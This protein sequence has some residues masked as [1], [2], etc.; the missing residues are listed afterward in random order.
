[1]GLVASSEGLGFEFEKKALERL[2]VVGS[3]NAGTETAFF[4]GARFTLDREEGLRLYT[5]AL[6][7]AQWCYPVGLND[8]SSGC[9]YEQ[10]WRPAAALTLGIE[11]LLGDTSPLTFAL[12]GGAWFVEQPGVHYVVSVHLRLWLD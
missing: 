12:H 8:Q 11:A 7:G 4:G 10:E 9:S 3:A 1:M 5:D 2:G 6:V